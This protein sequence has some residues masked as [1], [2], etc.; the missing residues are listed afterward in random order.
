MGLNYYGHSDIGKQMEIMED[1][2]IGFIVN[3]SVLFVAVA[4]GLGARK[5]TDVA[6]YVVLDEFKRY[7][8]AHIKS[9]NMEE[10]E[11]EMQKAIYMINRILF[12][13][14]R[15]NPE[16]YGNFSSTF[17]AVAI[18]NRKEIVFA[19]I[20][21]SRFYLFRQG[22]LFQMTKDDTRAQ[23][24]LDKKEIDEI[25][26]PL[27]PDR[28]VLT[29]YLGMP[30]VEPFISKGALQ[31][32]DVVLLV[33]N[34]VYEMLNNEQIEQIFMNTESSKQA[35]EWIVEGANE[36]GGVDNIAVVISYINF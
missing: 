36:V 27:H 32:N 25:E 10:V 12:N 29:K 26:Y 35:C 1:A 17:T 2:F 16:L 15:S 24:L 7:M 31:T 3:D 28:G 19:H 11:Q 5:G 21:N 4:D 23:E 18:N 22:K 13:Y 8:T 14:Q 33:T 20:G 9:D 6:S 30:E 34:G